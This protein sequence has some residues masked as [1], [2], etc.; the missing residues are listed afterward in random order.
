M[1]VRCTG[2]DDEVSTL[3]EQCRQLSKENVSMKEFINTKVKELSE[4]DQKW[5][6]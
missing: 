3:S 4:T 5:R 6:E 2:Y 1:N